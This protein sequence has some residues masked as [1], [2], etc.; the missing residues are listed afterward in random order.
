VSQ[1]AENRTELLAT[2]HEGMYASRSF[3]RIAV[4]LQRQGAISGFAEARGQE[5]AQIGVAAAI[6]PDEMIFP[7]YRHAGVALWRGISP[8]ELLRFYRRQA[9]CTWDWR[10]H[11]FAAY[12]VP[13]ASQLSHACGW[14]LGRQ[15]A[16]QAGLTAVFFG[17]GAFS[18]GEAHEAL[19]YAAVLNAPVLYICENNGWAVSLPTERQT[20]AARLSDRALGYGMRG[21]TVDGNDALAV[22]TAASEAAD[23][24]R[25]QSAPY[26]L[27]CTTYRLA[28]HTTADDDKRY[29]QQLP[30]DGPTRDPLDVLADQSPGGRTDDRWRAIEESVDRRLAKAVDRFLDEIQG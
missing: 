20:K 22:H 3:D 4:A 29:R 30:A 26:L 8:A 12:T 10:K 27:E 5:A 24:V 11:G 23:Y 7:S 21:S 16:G 1:I 9:L 28:P 25:A 18:Q 2:L 15:R 13:V 6:S 17:D 14:A 19:N